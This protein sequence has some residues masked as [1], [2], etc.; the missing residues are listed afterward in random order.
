M[1]KIAHIIIT[2]ASGS[3]KSTLAKKLAEEKDLEVV[4]LDDYPEWK[5][6]HANKEARDQNYDRVARLLVKKALSEPGN[7]ILEGQQF[8]RGLNKIPKN[9][10]F[11]LVNPGKDVVIKQRIERSIRKGKESGKLV[12]KN[13]IESKRKIAEE[14][15]QESYNDMLRLGI[16]KD[17]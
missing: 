13:F 3:G 4:S 12:D 7:K 15:Y 9:H 17:V 11:I 5:K 8:L 6:F 2:G 14:L 1:F 16:E 10:E